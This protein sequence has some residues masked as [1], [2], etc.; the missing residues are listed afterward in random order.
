MSPDKN[1]ITIEK[2]LEIWNSPYGESKLPDY[3]K[4]FPHYHHNCRFHDSI[5][6][7]DGLDKFKE[8]CKRLEKR[9]KEIRMEVHAVA[10]NGNTFFIESTMTMKFGPAPLTPMHVNSKIVFDDNGLITLHRDYY[11]LW[12]DTFDII[13]GIGK[14]YRWFM[15]TVMG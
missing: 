8:M 2:F 3:S 11:D 9:C 1:E 14:L 13:P 15:R 4:I 5:Q 12:G 10:K 7:F 6:S